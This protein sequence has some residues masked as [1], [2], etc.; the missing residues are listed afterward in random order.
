MSKNIINVRTYDPKFPHYFAD[1]TG[2]DAFINYN[3][4]GLALAK[5]PFHHE[6]SAFYSKRQPQS[7]SPLKDAVAFQYRPDGTGRDTY[8]Y[9]NSGGLKN[10]SFTPYD[11][12]NFHNSLRTQELQS[13]KYSRL[14][15]KWDQSADITSYLNWRTPKIQNQVQEFAKQQKAMVQRLSPI[16]NTTFDNGNK[17]NTTT[18][19]MRNSRLNIKDNLNMTS[20]GFN[21]NNDKYTSSLNQSIEMNQ[22]KE[23][24]NRY[25]IAQDQNTI[26]KRNRRGVSQKLIS[27]SGKAQLFKTQKNLNL[28]DQ[29]EGYK[30]K[31]LDLSISKINAFKKED[32]L[33]NIKNNQ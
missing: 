23:F 4:G 2:K 16:K 20:D 17:Y 26:A 28:D 9:C 22:G 7:P 3:N 8:I 32:L 12:K 5:I 11:E 24:Q 30:R 10:T 27:D 19:T 1:G 25:S 6:S 31:L 33:K 18:S 29:T 21:N 15:P 14:K 13:T